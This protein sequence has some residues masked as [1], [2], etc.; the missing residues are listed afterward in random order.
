MHNLFADCPNYR[1][2]AMQRDIPSWAII[3]R[4][5]AEIGMEQRYGAGAN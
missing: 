2:P 3:D 4:Q 1:H 5:E